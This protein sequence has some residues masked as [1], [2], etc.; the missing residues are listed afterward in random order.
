MIILAADTSTSMGSVALRDPEGR[1]QRE[2]LDS[3]RP[4]SE[5]L[6]TAVEKILACAGLDRRDVQAIAVGTGPG[7]FTGLRVG[8]ATF[9][10]WAAAAMLPLIPVVSMDAVALPVLREGNSVM[11]V[12]DARKGEVYAAY[13]PSLGENSLPHRQG[14]VVLLPNEGVP[15]WILGLNDPAVCVT[16]TG[17][18]LLAREGLLGDLTCNKDPSG[19]PDAFWILELAEILLPLNRTVEPAGLIP[20]YVRPP[21]AKITAPGAMLTNISDDDHRAGGR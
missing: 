1:I 3:S 5:T 14:D 13:Y 18:L 19:A 17:L 6:L 4:H 9:K 7:A 12:A 15:E 10:A 8:L 11:V 21:D 2:G 16:G 20:C